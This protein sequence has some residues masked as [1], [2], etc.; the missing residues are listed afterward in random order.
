MLILLFMADCQTV[1]DC[2]AI[3]PN[4]KNYNP[5]TLPDWTIKNE[6]RVLPRPGC[7]QLASAARGLTTIGFGHLFG[8]RDLNIV[9]LIGMIDEKFV[10]V[11]V[12]L[13][14][15]LII[16]RLTQAIIGSLTLNSCHNGNKA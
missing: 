3:S 12:P 13:Q 9:P 4:R 6:E 5:L 10:G 2:Q 7:L 8:F 16:A 15:R 14:R 1:A 11:V